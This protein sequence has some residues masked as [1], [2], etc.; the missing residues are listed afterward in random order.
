MPP[1]A[2]YPD[3]LP[4]LTDRH[5][6]VTGGASGLGYE[7]ARALALAGADITLGVRDP[8]RAESAVRTLRSAAPG[9]RVDAR[10]IDVADFGSVRAFAGDAV[11][12]W[13]R[14]DLVVHNAGVFG[15][16]PARTADGVERQ[17]ATNH[18]GPVLLTAALWPL[19]VRG[20]ASRVVTVTSDEYAKVKP[21]TFD[22]DALT[23]PS[24]MSPLAWY[25]VTKLAALTF[26]RALDARCQ[27]A[28]VPVMALAAHPGLAAT[29]LATGVDGIFQRLTMRF[30]MAVM[31]QSPRGGSR[32]IVR[33]A[34][35]PD[36][37]GGAL[38]APGGFGGMR[39]APVR[40]ALMRHAA[41]RSLGER[42]W[43][44]SL[45]LTGATFP[46]LT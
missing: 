29:H 16:P 28:G 22:A 37:E 1:A 7:T 24:G 8:A 36:A 31:G 41:D 25:G 14:L 40:Q 10:R 38:W 11:R 34:T 5:A 30:G 17:L 26:A 15:T 2:D 43:T 12:T 33:A 23:M 9:R 42:I 44:A 21:G 39:G 19:L 27:A 45:R 20:P 13:T 4:D 3:P 6:L 32:P 18:L 46:G 35:A